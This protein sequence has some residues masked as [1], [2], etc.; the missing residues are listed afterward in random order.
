MG[1]QDDFVA[2]ADAQCGDGR[3]ERVIAVAA[4]ITEAREAARVREQVDVQ[5]RQQQRLESI[6]TLA[7]GVAHEINNP[8]QGIMNYAELISRMPDISDDAREFAGE[9]HHESQRVATIVR[10]L[11]SFSREEHE[12][13]MSHA[14]VREIIEGTLSLIRTVIGKDQ[15][16]LAVYAPAE[17]VLLECRAQQIRQVVMNLVTNARDAINAK[18]VDEADRRIRIDADTFEH[19]GRAWVRLSV[20]D[21]GGGVPPEVLPHIFDPF[22]TTKGRDQGTGLGLAVSHGIVTEHGGRLALANQPGV[23]ARFSIELPLTP[24]SSR[25]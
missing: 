1:W 2:R 4:D 5:R 12:Q 18:G 8:V 14:D 16:Q 21:R 20:E 9:I 3:V 17:P 15:I 23:G 22:F 6:G 19:E 11:L 25:S 13:S 10:S 7:S 24:E